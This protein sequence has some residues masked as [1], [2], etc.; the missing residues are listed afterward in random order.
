MANAS[1]TIAVEE[2]ER[3][4]KKAAVADD[5]VVQLEASLKDLEAGRIKRVR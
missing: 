5:L 2:Y 4:K 1:V 3:L